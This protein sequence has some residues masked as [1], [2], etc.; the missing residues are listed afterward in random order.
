MQSLTIAVPTF[1]RSRKLDRLL[2]LFRKAIGASC[3]PNRVE[4]IVCDNASTDSTESVVSHHA[5]ISPYIKYYR[6]E[7]NLGFDG[8]IKQ[9][10]E[11]C[12]TNFIWFFSDDDIPDPE[13]F[14]RIIGSL[15]E[16]SPDVLLFSFR[17]PAT[18]TKGAFSFDPPLY[19]ENDV[20]KCIEMLFAFPKV[21]TFVLRKVEFSSTQESFFESTI[22][23]GFSFIVL[24]L[25]VLDCA[26]RPQLAVISE[27]LASSDEDF[28]KLDWTPEPFLRLSKQAQHPLVSRYAPDLKRLLQR[29]GYLTAISLSYDAK[30]GRS[31]V[32]DMK[33]YDEFIS[34]L[35]FDGRILLSRPRQLIKFA[36]LKLKLVPKSAFKAKS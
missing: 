31:K 10:Y 9:C 8:N 18:E 7:K 35:A 26:T 33:K 20:R 5:S 15:D 23:D 6:N 29:S 27:P 13:A 1:N 34:N 24:A 22:G 36:L 2:D 14:D 4:L 17:Q 28:D 25:T 3:C 11:L 16:L 19:R 21:S 12:S 32:T 30:S